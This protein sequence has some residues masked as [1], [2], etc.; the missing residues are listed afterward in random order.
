[1]PEKKINCISS[2]VSQ[3]SAKSTPKSTGD[4]IR[5]LEIVQI[6]MHQKFHTLHLTENFALL[7]QKFLS[8]GFS[9]IRI[10]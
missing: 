1:V 9:K 8:L 5:F 2:S 10:K 7:N 4:L 3:F 6:P